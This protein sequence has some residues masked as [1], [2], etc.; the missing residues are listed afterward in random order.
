M[1][2]NLKIINLFC[3]FTMAIFA[4]IESVP[5]EIEGKYVCTLGDSR[6]FRLQL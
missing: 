6:F 3:L 1:M 2:H 4:P 5:I